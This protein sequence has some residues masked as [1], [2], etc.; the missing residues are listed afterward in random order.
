MVNRVKREICLHFLMQARSQHAEVNF[1]QEKCFPLFKHLP[2]SSGIMNPH[3]AIIIDA[4]DVLY[5]QLVREFSTVRE[6]RRQVI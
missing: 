5:F 4:R 1:V 6:I 2:H 3:G